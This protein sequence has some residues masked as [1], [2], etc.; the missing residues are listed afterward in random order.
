MWRGRGRF[1]TL[2][3][4]ILAYRRP[5]RTKKKM[6]G[7]GWLESHGKTFFL[8]FVFTF[9]GGPNVISF[10]V[11]ENQSLDYVSWRTQKLNIKNKL[12]LHLKKKKNKDYILNNVN[13][14]LPCQFAEIFLSCLSYIHTCTMNLM[15]GPIHR[16]WQ[17]FG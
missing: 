12:R 9:L 4:R 10:S 5:C 15:R 13:L 7:F 11:Y 17:W 8:L 2:I 3:T 1:S 6:H 16:K 14:L